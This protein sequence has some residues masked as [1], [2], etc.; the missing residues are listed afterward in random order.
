MKPLRHRAASLMAMSALCVWSCF[1]SAEIRV[2]DD[3]GATVVLKRPAQRIV[4][5]APHVVELLFAAGAGSRVIATAEYSDY[6]PQ[7]LSIPR[8]G[9]SG[10]FD[11]ERIVALQPDLVI[12]WS[13]GNPRHAIEQ[14]RAL[15]LTVYI[16]ELRH[17]QDVTRELERFGELT[18]TETT[19]RAE[20]KRFT[21]RYEA[22]KTRYGNRRPLRLF[23]Q[24]LDPVLLTFN[25]KHQVSEIMRTCG[26]EN[27]FADLPVL[28]SPV[29]EEAVL[30][31]DPDVIIA[32]GIEPLW[33]EWRPRWQQRTQLK[34]T[35]N[36]TIY[37]IPADI[38]HRQSTR[39]I[40][41]AERLCA[42][43]DEAR[44]QK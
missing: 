3:T 16:T 30:K 11:I 22:L 18:G 1:A 20:A 38:I 7:A 2:V 33:Q 19:A 15:G 6:P 24:V 40:E 17:L 35:R 29:S 14:L 34:A 8:I 44:K 27:I 13:S 5:L 9:G 12:A 32:G 41:G 21:A 31:Q 23:Y 4:S 42:I 43:L 10:G 25:G 39:V 37:F 36:G 26:A 28:A